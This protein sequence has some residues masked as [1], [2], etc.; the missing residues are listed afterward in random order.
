MESFDK[1]I[2]EEKDTLANFV[3]LLMVSFGAV[4]VGSSL[5]RAADIG[6]QP[7]M[8]F[9]IGIFA[10]ISLFA[11]FRRCTAYRL[12]VL[13]ILF[14]FQS[15]AI[16]GLYTFGLPGNGPLFSL[17]T[18][19][20]A[21][22][23]VNFRTA[24]GIAGANACLMLYFGILVSHGHLTYDF[25]PMVYSTAFSSWL[26]AVVSL[27]LIYMVVLQFICKTNMIV[28]TNIETINQQKKALEDANAAKNKLFSV[29]SHDLRSPF[30]AL[31]N[32]MQMLCEEPDA[33]SE[34]D[35]TNLFK[36]LLQDSEHTY[37]LLE[38]LL[39][40]AQS[41]IDVIEIEKK[42]IHLLPLVNACTGPHLRHAQNKHLTVDLHI[43]ADMLI[44]ADEP[45]MRIVLSNLIHNAI[46]FTPE[47]GVITV[48]AQDEGNDSVLTITDTGIGVQPTQI[49]RL[50]DSTDHVTTLGTEHE[51]GTGLG[52]GLC[53]D[54]V[55]KNGGDIWVES[56]K[57]QGSI[58]YIRLNNC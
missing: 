28:Y 31:I 11:L 16:T 21:A 6:W 9:H 19:I 8:Y 56:P 14:T 10:V 45:S 42:H 2:S 13:L 35:K 34:Q 43:S 1:D 37:S 22:A 53:H 18:P 47:G 23:L 33:F 4:G 50:F 39:T 25:D 27:L 57:E 36:M 41:Q 15:I 26:T 58:F 40:W 46:K 44:W 20:I 24:L 49:Q 30:N 12:K 55:T 29:I 54:L 38:N 48:S 7:N 51:K 5:F 17:A 3:L 52:L 32:S